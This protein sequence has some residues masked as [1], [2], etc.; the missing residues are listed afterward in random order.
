M[1]VTRVPSVRLAP[2]LNVAVA[3]ALVVA[4]LGTATLAS[5][6]VLSLALAAGA[7]VLAWGWAGTLALPTPRGTVG[8]IVVGGLA[9]VLSVASRE[10]SPW[11][12]WVPAAL[13]LAMIAAFT[14]QLL[15]RDGRPRVVQSVSSVV[16]GLALVACGVL[17]VPV[18]HSDDG[19]AL[20]IGALG[21]ALASSVTDLLGRWPAL[22]PWL[23]ALAMTAGGLV[24]V[25]VAVVL[26]VPW[27]TGLLV[28]VVS[29]A[30]SHAA[31]A[32]MAPL[33]TLAHARPRL[34]SALASVLVVG[35]VPYLV[36]QVLVATALPG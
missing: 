35:V 28:G 23:S 4:V 17:M 30:L 16:L 12:A 33:P 21:A 18:S 13:S 26:G 11:L 1:S 15:R 34:I 32:L 22:A 6:L 14:H 7:V 5:P 20:V 24:G 31:R 3:V 9:L 36:A 2:A 8:V 10:E 29:G 27:T 19:V 25:L